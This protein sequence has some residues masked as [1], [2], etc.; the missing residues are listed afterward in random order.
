MRFSLRIFLG[1]LLLVAAALWVSLHDF[2]RELVPGM[3]QS[4]EE[5]LVDTANLLAIVVEDEVLGGEIAQGDFAARMTAF[6]ERSLNAVIYETAKTDPSL[7]VYITDATGRVVYDSRG[8]ALGQ[9]YSR[10]NDVHLTLRGRYGARTTRDDP[11]DPRTSVMYV[12]API[13]HGE[14]IVGVLTVGKPSVVVLPFLEA[15]RR[16]LWI[17]SGW[18]LGLSLIVAGLLA[19]GLTRSIRKLTR[20]ADDVTADQRVQPPRIRER[21]LARL[22]SAMDTMRSELQGK[23]YVEHYLHGLTHELKSPLAAIEGAA[24]LLDGEVPEAARRRFVANIRA[25]SRRL[26]QVVERLLRL[27]ALES[28]AALEEIRPC[29]TRQLVRDVVAER[30]VRAGSAGVEV[31]I[32]GETDT[33][34]EGEP[35]LLRQAVGNLL[36]NAIDFSPPGGTIEIRAAQSAA[37]WVLTVRDHGPGFPSYAEKRLFERFYSLPRPGGGA[38][39]TGLG[40]TAVREVAQLH[41]GAISLENHAGGGVVATLVIPL[42]QPS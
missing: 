5:V 25:E 2:R 14:E 9:D 26:R 10:W 42:R 19:F 16:S 41:H 12:A 22:A 15:A 21:E 17:K 8:Q 7:I 1:F 37:S 23:K 35:F 34:V 29:G 6:G 18:L 3:R 11:D 27:A 28:R 30:T 36:D 40:L 39:S 4:V 31:R 13:V 24:E 32:D 38:K 20:Y 33:T